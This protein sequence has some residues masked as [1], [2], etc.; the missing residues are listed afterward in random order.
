MV[1]T[2]LIETFVEVVR[3]G[4]VTRAAVALDRSQPA[5]SHRLKQL[6]QAFGTALF[7]KVGRE[8]QLTEAGERLFDE[9]VDILSRIQGLHQRVHAEEEPAGGVAVGTTPEGA[10][11]LVP[12]LGIALNQFPQVKPVVSHAAPQGLR[13]ALVAGELDFVLLVG[14][15]DETGLD[16]EQIGEA[17]LVVVFAPQSAPRGPLDVDALRA[18]RFIGWASAVEP[19]ATRVDEWATANRLVDAS[20]PL[21]AGLTSV[22]GLVQAGAGYCV[23]P[24]FAVAP[25]VERGEVVV[26]ALASPLEVLP[27]CMA[28]R[29]G[30]MGGAAADPLRQLIIDNLPGQ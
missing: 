22:I 12:G 14:P 26:R 9:A 15:L 10:L 19:A 23:A 7:E 3:R 8:L 5:V 27:I 21:V 1:E 24:D 2:H 16:V 18:H 28:T 20:T 4:T 17:K 6:E 25:Y 13:S 30:W 11:L 29:A